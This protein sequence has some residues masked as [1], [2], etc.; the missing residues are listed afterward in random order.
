MQ[1]FTS[2]IS[3]CLSL[4]L[5]RSL[6]NT[7]PP[8]LSL[9]LSLFHN[10]FTLIIAVH[11]FPSAHLNAAQTL[12]DINHTAHTVTQRFNL[13][14][15]HRTR[16]RKL[17]VLKYST[18][19]F[20]L[21]GVSAELIFRFYLIFRNYFVMCVERGGGWMDQQSEDIFASKVNGYRCIRMQIWVN[22]NLREWI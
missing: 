10:L 9:S 8:L 18:F 17:N 2:N 5:T 4:D 21:Y 3:L 1:H 6:S 11:T 14:C 16:T 12:K 20:K 13:G 7:L 19:V 22:R 15:I